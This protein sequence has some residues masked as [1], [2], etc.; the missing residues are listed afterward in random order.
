MPDERKFQLWQ[1]IEDPNHRDIRTLRQLRQSMPHS[2]FYGEFDSFAEA[3][4]ERERMGHPDSDG[5]VQ[6]RFNRM[7]VTA[8]PPKCWNGPQYDIVR[9]SPPTVVYEYRDGTETWYES[10]EG[11]P[12]HAR[13][14]STPAH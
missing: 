14:E 10:V 11:M 2:A 1:Y 4:G 9:H 7:V 5:H 13:P 12:W 8:S 6:F 3:Y